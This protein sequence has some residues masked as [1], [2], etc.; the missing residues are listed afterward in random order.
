MTTQANIH[1]LE[2]KESKLFPNQLLRLDLNNPRLQTG[3]NFSTDD[4]SQAIQQLSDI[5]ALDELVLSICTNKYLNL[6]PLIVY[7]DNGQAPYTVLEGNRRLAAIRIIQNPNL[8]K[9]LGIKL[10]SNI[11]KEVI[12]SFDKLLVYRV[13]NPDEARAFIGFKH[14]NGP[15][16]WDA[17]AKAKYVTEWYIKEFG[18]ISIPEIAAKMGDNNNTLRSYIYALLILEQAEKTNTW[19]MKDKYIRGRFGFSHFYTALGREEYQIY[20]GLT[21]G[22]SD[23]P[24]LDPISTDYLPNLAEVLTYLYGSRS[25]DRPSLIRSQNPDLKDI[26]LAIINDAARKI[27]RNRGTLDE[28]RDALK[29]PSDAFYDALISANLKLSRAIELFPKYEGGREDIDK[30]IS[31]IFERADTLQAINERKK[32]R[33]NL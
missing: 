26:G 1:N 20:L 16:R 18:K 30:V 25:D 9:E 27:L 4:D 24:P 31:E 10:P 13:S 2:L 7:S 14:I 6:E 3:E 17:Y 28:A 21:K 32:I 33:K 29:D 23:T 12:E 11:P 22:W 15:Q 8:A 19:S 5:A